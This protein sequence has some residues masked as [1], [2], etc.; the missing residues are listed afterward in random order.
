MLAVYFNLE[1]VDTHI[2]DM[3]RGLNY[4]CQKLTRIVD[5]S[6]VYSEN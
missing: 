4:I 5:T 3:M 6:V 2:V 1:N